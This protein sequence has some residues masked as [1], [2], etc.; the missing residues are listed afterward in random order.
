MLQPRL[1]LHS[2]RHRLDVD[3]CVYICDLDQTSIRSLMSSSFKTCRLS[4]TLPNQSSVFQTADDI[5]WNASCAQ[6]CDE[7]ELSMAHFH[8]RRVNTLSH[9][10]PGLSAEIACVNNWSQR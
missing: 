6:L 5:Q 7:T 8:R 9:T 1:G 10:Q 3:C 2:T 4:A